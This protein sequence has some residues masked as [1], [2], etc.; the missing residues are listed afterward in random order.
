MT[1][2]EPRPRDET[3]REALEYYRER[4]RAPGVASGG[5]PRNF[6]CMACDGVVPFDF[7]GDRCPHCGAPIDERVRRYFNWVEINEPPKGD[8]AFLAR[9]ALLGIALV[10]VVAV[11][12]WWILRG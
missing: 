4:S 9:V 1:P 8:A 7:A 3:N 12:T 11:A 10:F 2:D 6:Y 5:G